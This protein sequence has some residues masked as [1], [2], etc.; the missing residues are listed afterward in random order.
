MA[1]KSRKDLSMGNPR[2]PS[3]D[4]KTNYPRGLSRGWKGVDTK[5]TQGRFNRQQSAELRALKK[6]TSRLNSM[7]N[8]RIRRLQD[9]GMKTPALEKWESEGG[10]FFSVAGKDWN[11]TQKELAR[12]RQFIDNK[13]SSIRDATRVLKDMADNTGIVYDTVA[14]LQEKARTFFDLASKTEQYLRMTQDSA[15]AIGYQKIWEAIN[16]YVEEQNIEL[17]NLTDNAE[18]MIEEITKL[19]DVER[20]KK[21]INRVIDK[22]GYIFL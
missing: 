20:D 18:S 21:I 1:R 13:T 22:D 16:K 5:L 8:K 3:D 17:D 4:L 11:E 12:V 19:I 15:S 10:Q 7:A 6:E 14:S 2:V 9:K